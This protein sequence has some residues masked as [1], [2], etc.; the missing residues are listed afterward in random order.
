MHI[1]PI[2]LIVLHS[3]GESSP[4]AGSENRV[5]DPSMDDICEHQSSCLDQTNHQDRETTWC[6][7]PTT[8]CSLSFPIAGDIWRPGDLK[9]H[10]SSCPPV[11]QLKLWWLPS[12]KTSFRAKLT[13]KN[14]VT[15]SESKALTKVVNLIVEGFMSPYS[16]F[17]GARVFFTAKGNM[18]FKMCMAS[19][20]STHHQKNCQ[21]LIPRLISSNGCFSESRYPPKWCVI[22]LNDK[23]WMIN[24]HPYD[25]RTPL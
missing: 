10:K 2:C 14:P 22:T 17:W 19:I 23:Y 24:G 16:I 21:S 20:S 12:A 3:F 7:A 11:L 5:G 25:L 15:R 8:S 18:H 1:I 9:I 13:W 6:Y 4:L